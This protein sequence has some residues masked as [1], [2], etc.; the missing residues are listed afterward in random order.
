[1]LINRGLSTPVVTGCCK[2]DLQRGIDEREREKTLAPIWKAVAL[3][4][5]AANRVLK[6]QKKKSY[7]KMKWMEGEPVVLGCLQTCC[8]WCPKKPFSAVLFTAFSNGEDRCQYRGE[9]CSAFSLYCRLTTAQEEA[10]AAAAL[11]QST[12]KKQSAKRKG[13]R[14]APA[15]NEGRKKSDKF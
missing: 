2:L 14:E 4:A 12:G 9:C 10:E 15:M 3:S 8:C 7:N 6:K 1:M 13:E 5:A 11:G